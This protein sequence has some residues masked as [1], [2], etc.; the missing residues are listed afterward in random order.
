LTT[1]TGSSNC[2]SRSFQSRIDELPTNSTPPGFGA[3]ARS[4]ASKA[5]KLSCQRAGSAERA[6]GAGRSLR[7]GDAAASGAAAVCAVARVAP[8]SMP[9][10]ISTPTE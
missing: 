8:A 7:V 5:S 4:A 10:A 1:A 9:A 6:L 2:C 3:A